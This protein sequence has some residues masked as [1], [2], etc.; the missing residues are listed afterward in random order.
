MF[1]LYF[2]TE[3]KQYIKFAAAVREALLNSWCH[4]ALRTPL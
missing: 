4:L 2:M 1:E 3:L